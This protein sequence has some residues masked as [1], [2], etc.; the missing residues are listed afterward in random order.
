M[1][2]ENDEEHKRKQDIDLN[3]YLWSVLEREESIA[4]FWDSGYED[5]ITT[6]PLL[7]HL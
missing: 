7:Q 2:N 4:F 6:I 1:Q 3:A 5:P